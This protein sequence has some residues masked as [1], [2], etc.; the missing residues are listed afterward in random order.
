MVVSRASRS[1]RLGVVVEKG[2]YVMS[3]TASH[4]TATAS[5]P[6]LPFL[7]SHTR[8]TSHVTSREPHVARRRTSQVTAGPGLTVHN[9]ALPRCAD[10]ASGSTVS[11]W[12]C[13]MPGLQHGGRS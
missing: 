2:E 7:P 3:T 13:I 5:L 1:R 4:G 10:E 6:V 9:C 8:H 12:C 11:C